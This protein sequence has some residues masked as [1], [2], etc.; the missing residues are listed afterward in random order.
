MSEWL[1]KHDI[2]APKG[3]SRDQLAELVEANWYAG[4]SWTQ[5]QADGAQQWFKDV[6]NAA[7]DT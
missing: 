2:K 3:Y 4:K 5:Q 1:A 6:N 7:F